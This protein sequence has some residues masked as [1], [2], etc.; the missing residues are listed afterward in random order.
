ML[1]GHNINREYGHYVC[2]PQGKPTGQLFVF[3]P[4]TGTNDYTNIVKTAASIGCEDNP[5]PPVLTCPPPSS[6][7]PAPVRAPRRAPAPSSP[8]LATNCERVRANTHV[9][10]ALHTRQHAHVS[11]E[12]GAFRAM[13]HRR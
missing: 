13:P 4:G 8:I 2:Q 3:M 12:L 11:A 10:I 7:P 9:C 5:P 1:T 6:P